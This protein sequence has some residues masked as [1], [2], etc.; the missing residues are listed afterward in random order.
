MSKSLKHPDEKSK[1]HA[2]VT[3]AL[4][5]ELPFEDRLWIFWKKYNQHIT[6][7]VVLILFGFLGYQGIG[8]FKA[9]QVRKLQE[10][11][12]TAIEGG[13]ELAFAEANIKESLSG[14][15]FISLGDQLGV[16]GKYDEAIINYNKALIS[17]K[18]TPFGDRAR[19]GVALITWMKGDQDGAKKLL[20][21]IVNDSNVMGPIRAEA[22]YQMAFICLKE[23]DYTKSKELL[24]AINRIPNAG[25]WGQK[26]LI[27][28]DSTP[29]L[30]T[31]A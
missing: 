10:E 8:L 11:Y 16:D 28:R 30:S 6:L 29:G 27:L 1:K 2:E 15:V 24:D 17:L 18:S 5:T 22:A 31:K 26:A 4:L 9:S 19:L 23:N 20:N 25:I 7:G 13:H 14:S 21:E 3:S 12:R